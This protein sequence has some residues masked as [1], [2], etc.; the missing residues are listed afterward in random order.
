MCA[1]PVLHVHSRLAICLRS[2][3]F[4]IRT[5]FVYYSLIRA[6]QKSFWNPLNT[7][8]GLSTASNSVRENITCIKLFPVI[9][10]SAYGIT[11]IFLV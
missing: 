7:R 8:G 4:R 5:E 1:S 10:Y 2:S 11:N 6:V 9:H 3:G